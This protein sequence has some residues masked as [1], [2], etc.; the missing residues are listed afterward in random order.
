MLI[1]MPLPKYHQV[2]LVLREQLHEGKFFQGLPGE[3]A[4]IQRFGMAR[5]TVRRA[6]EQLA[7]EGSI[8]RESGR[9][10][11]ALAP[12]VSTTGNLTEDGQSA[13][14]T[15]LL[16][17]LVS[18]GLKTSVKM[19]RA[20]QTIWPMPRLPSTLDVSVGSALLAVAQ[21]LR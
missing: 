16:E 12:G 3:A 21:G 4:L 17:N 1:A 15:G 13:K 18:M 6:L 11:R 14:L 10:T 2:C 7:S 19:G 20:H 9:G 5:V 8:S